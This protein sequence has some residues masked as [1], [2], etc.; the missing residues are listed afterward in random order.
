MIVDLDQDQTRGG[1][2]FDVLILGAGSAGPVLAA[3]LSENPALRG[4]PGRGRRHAR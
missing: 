4:R 2:G 3:R 1:V